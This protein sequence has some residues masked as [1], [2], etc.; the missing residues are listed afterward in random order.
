MKDR[1]AKDKE[2][3]K[4]LSDL[5]ANYE[6]DNF[7]ELPKIRKKIHDLANP[8]ES[9]VSSALRKQLNYLMLIRLKANANAV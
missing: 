1:K 2:L 5:L 9:Q 3:E 8:I 4:L 6:D 7:E